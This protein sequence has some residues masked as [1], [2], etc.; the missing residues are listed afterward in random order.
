VLW[1]VSTIVLFMAARVLRGKAKFTSTL[2]VTGFAQSAYVLYLL[3]FLPVI[4]P[5]ARFLA[6]AVSFFAVWV[7]TATAHNLRGWRTRCCRASM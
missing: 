5:V 1:L 6:V 4:G 2:R 7:G 3:G